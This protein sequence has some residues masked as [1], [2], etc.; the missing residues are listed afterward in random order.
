MTVRQK[1]VVALGSAVLTLLVGVA[2]SFVVLRLRVAI[3][4][5]DH[6]NMVIRQ[7]DGVLSSMADAETGQRGY[8]ITGDSAYLNPYHDGRANAEAHVA[9]LR[10]LVA[11]DAEQERRIDTLGALEERKVRELD[12]TV[13]MRAVNAT[14]A[15]DRVRSG[16]GKAIMDSARDIASRISTIER[17]RLAERDATRLRTRD[18]ALAVIVIGTLGAFLLAFLINR[19][20]RTD[21]IAQE[22][23]H[24]QLEHQARQLEDQAMELEQAVEQLRESTTQAEEAREAAEVANRAKNDFLAVMSHELRTPLNAIVGYAE[25][26]HDGIA[27]P[28]NDQQRE[29]LSRVQLSATHLVELVDEILSFSRIESGQENIRRGPV[30]VAQVTREAGALVEPVVAAKGLRFS[31]EV[32][33]EQATFT[34]D[35]AKV[36]QILVNLLSNAIKFT[37]QGEIVLASIVENGRVVF[38]VRDTGIGI[39]PE[40]QTRVFET[41]WQVDQTATRKA[42]GAGLGLSVSRRLAR[43]LGGDLSV[44]SEL[45]KGSRFRFWV[46]REGARSSP[47]ATR[48]SPLAT[49]HSPLAT[50]HS[51][52]RLTGRSQPAGASSSLRS[53]TYSIPRGSCRSRATTR[54][55]LTSSRRSP[56]RAR[57]ISRSS[58][59]DPSPRRRRW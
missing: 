29:Q 28:V 16:V 18:L 57:S 46:P 39:A 24:E 14:A 27:G 1:I 53:P 48:H 58:S 37:D 13:G 17:Q 47:L 23:T 26:L 31:L 19:S 21:V 8:L 30:E 42:G 7:L 15:A 33:N 52:L 45:G 11:D 2:A 43:V 40:N 36:R 32:P 34:S 20:I 49:R 59:G 9:A 3:A 54:R 38:E 5:V 55:T 51:P 50:R 6:T 44:E 25:L 4:A 56:S 10:D 41:F 35:A 22:R 12:Q